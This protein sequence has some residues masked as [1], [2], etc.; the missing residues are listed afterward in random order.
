MWSKKRCESATSAENQ[1]AYEAFMAKAV[2]CSLHPLSFASAS[3]RLTF[4]LLFSTEQND[5]VTLVRLFYPSFLYCA[6]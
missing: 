1:R 2:D 4:D 5:N 6:M 3:G